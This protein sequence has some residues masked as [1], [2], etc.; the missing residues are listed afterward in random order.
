MKK[1]QF[2]TKGGDEVYFNENGDPAAKYEIINWQPTAKGIVDFV[3]VGLYDASLPADK[4]LNLQN[5]SLIWAQNSQ[6][7]RYDIFTDAIEGS[8]LNHYNCTYIFNIF[9]FFMQVPLSVCSE[10]CPPGTRKVLKKGKPICCYDCLR[11]AEG[12]I[13]NSTGVVIYVCRI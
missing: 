1:I 9:L 10:K 6:E 12:E 8:E 7:V 4:Q 13:S 11:C 2:K 5:T 3:T